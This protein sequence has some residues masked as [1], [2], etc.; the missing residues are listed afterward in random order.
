MIHPDGSAGGYRPPHLPAPNPPAHQLWRFLNM[1][2]GFIDASDAPDTEPDDEPNVSDRPCDACGEPGTTDELPLH[3]ECIL[4]QSFGGIAQLIVPEDV[5]AGLINADGSMTARQS[6]FAVELCI[7]KSTAD[8]ILRR[9]LGAGDLLERR[10]VLGYLIAIVA[11]DIDVLAQIDPKL[12]HHVRLRQ[13]VKG[14]ID[15]MTEDLD[16]DDD[17]DEPGSPQ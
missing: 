2:T 5:A 9:T 1:S 11:D 6:G 3:G 16:D 8:G 15:A 12:A 13:A 7:A 14:L 17:D 4:R 10:K